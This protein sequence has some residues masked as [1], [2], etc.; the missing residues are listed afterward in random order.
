[1]LIS[2]KRALS[3][4][5]HKRSPHSSKGALLCLHS[6]T[7]DGAGHYHSGTDGYPGRHH[8]AGADDD[9]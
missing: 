7:H 8:P 5:P 6:G 2:S 3:L 4:Q 9:P 1:M